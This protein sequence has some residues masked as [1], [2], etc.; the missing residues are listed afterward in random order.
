MPLGIEPRSEQK[1]EDVVDLLSNIHK[2]IPTVSE[3]EKVNVPGHDSVDV[4]KTKFHQ[5]ALGIKLHI[6]CMINND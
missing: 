5:I 4:T 3:T 1:L 2:Y 6:H